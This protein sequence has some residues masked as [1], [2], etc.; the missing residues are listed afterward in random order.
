VAAVSDDKGGGYV[1]ATVPA[2]AVPSVLSGV[3]PDRPLSAA[4]APAARPRGLAWDQHRAR[5]SSG[6]SGPALPPGGGRYSGEE[7]VRRWLN[8]QVWGVGQISN[9]SGLTVREVTN[10][11]SSMGMRIG[12]DLI[13]RYP[14]RPK[15][16]APVP[17][18]GVGQAGTVPAVSTG[19]ASPVPGTAPVPEDLTRRIVDAYGA[20]HSATVADV[21]RNLGIGPD[22]VRAVLRAAGVT[23]RQG[24]PRDTSRVDL[25]D[26]DLV[27]RIRDLYATGLNQTEVAATCGMNAPMVSTMMARHKIPVRSR[28]EQREATARLRGAGTARN[29]S[30]SMQRE[31]TLDDVRQGLRQA[32]D[33]ARQLAATL[34]RV[35]ER[36]GRL[37]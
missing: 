9:N 2:T 18:P 14:Q 11:A 13:A 33:G 21:A 7:L 15:A 19:G 20:S 5:A 36:M 37:P 27:A 8:E 35:I 34:D 22:R 17:S 6:G 23:I 12:D 24:R 31:S 29:G 16:P 4:P 26:P 32:A 3:G 25:D 30:G 28:M 1:R 10:I